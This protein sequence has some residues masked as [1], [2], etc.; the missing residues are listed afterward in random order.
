M[1]W[2][3]DENKEF[4]QENGRL[5]EKIREQQ[6]IITK[7]NNQIEQLNFAIDDLLTYMSCD[8]IKKQ[9]EQLQRELDS[10]KPVMFQDMRKGTIILYSKGDTD[11]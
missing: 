3:S 11:E 2:L 1:N 5:K 4:K 7:L 8:E 9:N 10:F 6:S